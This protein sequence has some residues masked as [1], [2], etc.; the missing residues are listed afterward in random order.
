MHI[1]LLSVISFLS[2]TNASPQVVNLLRDNANFYD[3]HQWIPAFQ[4]PRSSRSPCPMLNTLAN[5]GFLPRD[6]RNITKD[7]FNNAQVSALNFDP[8]LASG[9]TNAM[10][11]KLGSPEN[12]S[13]A[14]DL[15]DFASH[16]HTEHDASLTRL[17]IIQGS[18]IDTQPSMVDFLLADSNTQDLNTSSIG[19]SRARR[20][21]ESV[22]IG[23]PMLSEAFT[24]FA[25]LE[26]SFILLVFG[27]GAVNNT[28]ARGAPKAQVHYWLNNERFPTD[29]GYVRSQTVLTSD[30]QRSLI[31]GIKRFHDEYA[32]SN[33]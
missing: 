4:I 23:S 30:L 21:A 22:A 19:Y 1:L 18:I 33:S 20:E 11:A 31:G 27:I 10:V 9:T 5:H 28:D 8:S 29:H 14:F 2:A 3:M 7:D 32:G 16:N 6:G 25:Q 24:A 13:I 12:G 17:D 26:A 15:S